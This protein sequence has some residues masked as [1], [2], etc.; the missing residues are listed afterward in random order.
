MVLLTQ[1]PEEL[2]LLEF[3]RPGAEDLPRDWL[4][5]LVN[6]LICC[7]NALIRFFQGADVDG[8]GA[9][10][11]ATW[12]CMISCNLSAR[13]PCS[14]R[15]AVVCTVSS[16]RVCSGRPESHLERTAASSTL[17]AKAFKCL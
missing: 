16:A 2:R 1:L 9:C 4:S 8:A 10:V 13:Q 12:F 7:V 3:R 17:G 15:S 5:C 11:A 6:T 14:S